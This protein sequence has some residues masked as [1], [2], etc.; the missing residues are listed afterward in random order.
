M[1]R[2]ENS[3]R[4]LKFAIL[5]KLAAILINFAARKVF[6]VI[7]SAEYLGLNGTFSNIL[8]MLALAELGVG[9]AI[10]YS[11]YKPLAEDDRGLI[12]SLMALYRKLYTVIGIVVAVLGAAVTPFLP[13]L[14]K[15]LPDI[16]HIYLIY[17]MFVADSALSYFFVYKQSLITADQKQYIVTAY[18][19]RIRLAATVV[20]TVFLVITHNY[21][22][23]LSLQIAATVLIN[24]LLARKADSMYPYLKGAKAEALPKE[25][26]NQ[27]SKNVRAMMAHKVGSVVVFGTDNLLIAY[28]VGSISVGIYSNYLM[29]TNGLRSIY[30]TV[31]SSLTASVGN[32]CSSEDKSHALEVFWRVCFI[33]EWLFGF[34]AICLMVLLN[35]FVELWLG[36]EY[37]FSLPIVFMI[38]LNFYV[39][40]MRQACLTFREAMGLYWYDRYKP[41]F[42]SVINFAVSALL[43]VKYGIVGIFIGTFVST[44]TTCFWVEPYVLFKYGFKAKVRPYFAR[45]ALNTLVVCVAAAVTW[46]IS[47][48]LPA[49]GLLPFICKL[50][51]CALVPNLFYLAVYG[52]TPEFEY[53][54][55]MVFGFAKRVFRKSAKR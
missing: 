6:V 44:M 31:F 46:F 45:Y 14:I 40:G 20:Q 17:L 29:I 7:L 37:L 1:S 4:N 11:M 54:K 23:Y 35:P 3:L 25:V 16:P 51:V 28:F 21:I 13:L 49:A 26:G 38:V 50:F 22:V 39:T 2:T 32:L 12:I 43:A 18:S 41:L 30:I 19:F 9:A 53:F 15:D 48:L 33:G 47:S 42:E 5:F 8:S 36:S 27:I 10:T 52:R 24:V 34:S 55:K